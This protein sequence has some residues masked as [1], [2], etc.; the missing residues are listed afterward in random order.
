MRNLSLI[1]IVVVISAICNSCGDSSTTPPKPENGNGNINNMDLV[2]DIVKKSQI[3]YIKSLQLPSGAIT[4]NTQSNSKICGYFA[5]FACIAL[6]KNPSTENTDVV[7]KYMQWYMGKL[8]G[9]V[10]TIQG[11]S[12]IVGSIYDY[13]AP[14]E[15]T[16]GN[17]DS[18]DSYAA[19][20]LMLAQE[21]AMLSAENKSWLM[22]YITKL[23]LVAKALET[24]LDTEENSIPTTFSNDD[25]DYLSIAS[26]VYPAKYLMD[27]SEV[28]RGLKSAKWL[29]DEGLLTTTSNYNMLVNKNTNSIESEFWQ[30]TMYNWIDNKDNEDVLTSSWDKFY[31]DATSQLYP[32]IFEVIDPYSSRANKL[33]TE[34]NKNYPNWSLGILPS[35]S[36]AWAILSFAAANINDKAR[37]EEYMKHIYSFNSVNKQ[38][39]HWYSFES[40]FVL[41]AIDKIKKSSSATPYIPLN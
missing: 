41:L 3:S 24:C 35:S 22:Q 36:H 18:V 9:E 1:I 25:D 28:N 11:G 39:D 19:T 16:Q 17:Y 21:F 20:F 31:A 26:Y 10:N 23:N 34:F 8:N 38:K 33:Y 27:N 4:D 30:S 13:Y 6:L 40:A 12:E 32:A 7:K 2:Y 15:T 29:H 14:N 5:N 37:V